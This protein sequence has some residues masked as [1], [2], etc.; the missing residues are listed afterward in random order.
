MRI[1]LLCLVA[2]GALTACGEVSTGGGGQLSDG[3]P[4]SGTVTKDLATN[5]Y[6]FRLLSP[7]G[8]TCEGVKGPSASPTAAVNIP[9]TCSNGATGNL[10]LTMNQFADEAIGSF[11]LSNG[12]TGS[13]K[14]G[15]R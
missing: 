14:F 7:E 11:A 10:I 2:I 12:K 15:G 3:R 13:I 4:V 1:Q 8:W 5:Q 9:V 6:T